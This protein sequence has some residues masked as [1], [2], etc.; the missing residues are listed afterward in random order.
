MSIHKSVQ[1]YDFILDFLY[2]SPPSAS[3]SDATMSE[4]SSCDDDCGPAVN[5]DRIH[6]DKQNEEFHDMSLDPQLAVSDHESDEELS[7]VGFNE[8]DTDD[9]EMGAVNKEAKPLRR[10]K[11]DPRE[12]CTCENCSVMESEMESYCCRE[13]T[14]IADT[15]IGQSEKTCVTLVNIFRKTI[16]DEDILKLQAT[17]L[18]DVKRNVDGTI[19]PEGLRYTAYTTFLQ[20]CS[21]RFCGK[22]RRYV[23][24]SC[25]VKR[26]R[27][28]YP[29]PAGKYKDFLP[30]AINS[31]I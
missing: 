30:G 3:E 27:N 12:W 25:V 16:E 4:S 18:Q 22:G 1:S 11:Q 14:L 20:M 23:L 2:S 10:L 5:N 29:S 7:I 28:L 9:D 13:S 17:S 19:R 21:L 26:I 15:V 6:R 8:Y 24:P 31:R